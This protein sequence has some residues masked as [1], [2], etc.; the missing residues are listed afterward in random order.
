MVSLADCAHGLINGRAASFISHQSASPLAHRPTA[1]TGTSRA[2]AFAG[3]SRPASAV[4]QSHKDRS[5]AQT[6]CPTQPHEQTSRSTAET[7]TPRKASNTVITYGFDGPEFDLM[8]QHRSPSETS[9][10][11]GP[12]EKCVSSP[13]GRAIRTLVAGTMDSLLR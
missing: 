11:V 2:T 3:S 4:S 1:F 7:P 12:C 9:A 8:G 5:T 13:Q 10:T 6:E